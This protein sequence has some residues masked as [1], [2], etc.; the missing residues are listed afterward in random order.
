VYSVCIDTKSRNFVKWLVS[1]WASSV[2]LAFRR[3][4]ALTAEEM[5]KELKRDH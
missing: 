2:T 1:L 5:I 3:T 4:S